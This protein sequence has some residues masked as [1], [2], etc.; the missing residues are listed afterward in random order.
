MAGEHDPFGR[1]KAAALAA[2]PDGVALV[3]R[4]ERIVWANQAFARLYGYSDETALLAAARG[5]R[6]T[7]L[8]DPVDSRSF[9]DR[10]AVLEPGES[11]RGK[12]SVARAIGTSFHRNVTLFRLEGGSLVVVVRDEADR[13]RFERALAAR[14]EL[15]RLLADHSSD[16]IALHEPDGTWVYVSPSGERLLGYGPAD[17]LGRAPWDFVHPDH[18]ERL[19]SC[20]LEA[21]A[22]R[23]GRVTCRIRTAR[24]GYIWVETAAE[25]VRPAG[26]GDFSGPFQVE[27]TSRDVTERKRLERQLAHQALHDSLTGLPNRTLFMSR[28][29]QADARSRRSGEAYGIL[30][31]DLDGFK[32]VNDLLGHAAGDD[33]LVGVARR[34]ESS[35]READTV[36]RLGGDE[37]GVLLEGVGGEAGLSHLV[38]RVERAFDEPFSVGGGDLPVQPSIG[39]ALSRRSEE[40]G[41]VLRR[42]DAAMYRSKRSADDDQRRR[43]AFRSI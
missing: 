7:F 24:E 27:T 22:G 17:L 37:F 25:P 13:R 21:A 12:L 41:E 23:P 2:H 16:L 29:A 34:L 42:A 5:R 35:V 43:R 32:A 8:Y 10:A 1:E 40:P 9:E 18:R 31:V 20:L 14:E 30:F 28:L 11:W 6:W 4:A 38:E 15:F 36:A 3:D 19:Q 26:E 39:V 33:L